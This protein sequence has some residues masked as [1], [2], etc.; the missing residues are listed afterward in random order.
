MFTPIIR[1]TVCLTVIFALGCTRKEKPLGTAENPLK[2][3]FV[4]SVDAKLLEASG[5]KVKA[6]LEKVTPYKFNFAVP[7]SYVAVVEAFGT[8]RADIAA[9]NTFGY[10]MANERYGANARIVFVRHGSETYNSQ[11]IARTDSGI[12]SVKDLE[13]KK[14]AYVDPAS[15][16]GYLLPAKLFADNSVKLA[17]TMFA[18]K[19]DNVVTMVYQKQVDAGATFYSPPKDG[20]IEDARRLV[21][22]QFP[23][24]EDKVKIVQLTDSIPNDPIIFRKEL[25]QDIVNT[26]V[27][28]L[29]AYVG[30]EEGKSVFYEIYGITGMVKTDDGRYDLVRDMLKTLGKNAADLSKK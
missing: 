11:I 6:H 2:F 15:T 24:V 4:P 7:S 16:S 28:A 23:D 1:L 19:H 20:K 27:D 8:N 26:V 5:E 13:G 9:V 30:T 3:F 14:F 18:Q 12:E 21:K 29:L 10:I 17:E 22:T 25:P